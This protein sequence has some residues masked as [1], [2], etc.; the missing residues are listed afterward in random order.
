MRACSGWQVLGLALGWLQTAGGAG[1]AQDAA[2][3]RALSDAVPK[4]AALLSG[5][6][7]APARHVAALW[8]RCCSLLPGAHRHC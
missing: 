5:V 2:R 6:P 4:I 1:A 8:S 3:D 7:P